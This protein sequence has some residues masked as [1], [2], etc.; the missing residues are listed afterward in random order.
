MGSFAYIVIPHNFRLIYQSIHWVSQPIAHFP[1]HSTHSVGMAWR[2][3]S[4]AGRLLLLLLLLLRSLLKPRLKGAGSS[5]AE[6]RTRARACVCLPSR[7][8]H[9]NLSLHYYNKSDPGSAQLDKPAAYVAP[10]PHASRTDSAPLTSQIYCPCSASR[11]Q[12]AQKFIT[13]LRNELIFYNVY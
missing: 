2:T 3:H 7:I 8:R 12:Q 13:E 9:Y 1:S 6:T 5:R 11:V 10:L 4:T